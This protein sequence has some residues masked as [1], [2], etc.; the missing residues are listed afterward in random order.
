MNEKR[1]INNPI[2][3]L[4]YLYNFSLKDV[5]HILNEKEGFIYKSI[6]DYSF[7]GKSFDYIDKFSKFL[8]VS[9][10]L[11]VRKDLRQSI[12]VNV[13][14]NMFKLDFNDYILARFKGLINEVYD[15]ENNVIIRTIEN[16]S[17]IKIVF[18]GNKNELQ[19]F[20]KN[21]DYV[22]QSSLSLVEVKSKGYKEKVFKDIYNFLIKEYD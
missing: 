10:D 15:S 4:L 5:A 6:N 19:K 1:L 22:K 13:L 21:I 18:S 8:N 9:Q 17:L 3:F 14:N 11:L 16:I 2:R 7:Y 12:N 20:L